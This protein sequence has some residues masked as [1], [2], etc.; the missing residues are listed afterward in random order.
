MAQLGARFHGME[1]VES[2]NLSR[3]TKAFKELETGRS[4]HTVL[5][6]H[7][8]PH[9]PQGSACYGP[10]SP[11]MR[12]KSRQCFRTPAASDSSP[13]VRLAGLWAAQNCPFLTVFAGSTAEQGC[14]GPYRSAQISKPG[15]WLERAGGQVN[16]S[17]GSA[18]RMGRRIPGL[19]SNAKSR[20]CRPWI[21]SWIHRHA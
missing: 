4:C 17:Q 2:S 15:P 3:S 12:E 7:G 10:R 11:P 21:F 13:A 18:A 20:S 5:F 19:C 1:E 9:G 14:Q 6:P 8:C 16:P